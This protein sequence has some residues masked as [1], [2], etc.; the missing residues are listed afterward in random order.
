M[1][2]MT[3]IAT[4][5]LPSAVLLPMASLAGLRVGI[6]V[7]ESASSKMPPLTIC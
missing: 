6:S 4:D 2:S 7:S 5:S 1:N 3:T